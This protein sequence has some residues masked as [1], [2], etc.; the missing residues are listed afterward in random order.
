MLF[1]DLSMYVIA[2]NFR[3]SSIQSNAYEYLKP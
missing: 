1:N 3:L 2:T